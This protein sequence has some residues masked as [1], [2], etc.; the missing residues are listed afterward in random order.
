M[1]HPNKANPASA[2]T[3]NGV[4]DFA[5]LA[6]PLENTNTSP[7]PALQLRCELVGSDQ[8]IAGDIM[9]SGAFDL[10]RRLLAA[11]ANPAAELV[12]YRNGTLA[13]RIKSIGAGARLTVRE[14][15]TDGP[16][17]VTWK[18]FPHRAVTAPVRSNRKPVQSAV[19]SESAVRANP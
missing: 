2:Q 13:L 5:P 14:T 19:L 18:P 17:L 16:R 12:C 1:V 4:Q 11:G 9:A 3:E 7:R 6:R 15:A 10:C 8:A